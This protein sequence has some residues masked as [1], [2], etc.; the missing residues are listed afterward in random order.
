MG[1]IVKLERSI[2]PALDVPELR[3]LRDVVRETHK[4][5]GI[6]GYKVGSALTILYGLPKLVEN[7]RDITD[8]PIIY[9][10]QKWMTDIPEI[11]KEV[12][13]AVKKSGADAIIGFPQSG[14]ITQEAYI[15]AAQGAGLG[16]IVGG[17]MTHKGYKRS[18][19]GYIEDE[20][21]KDMYLLSARLG[22]ID[23]VVPGNK[24]GKVEN[25]RKSIENFV[26]GFA[27]CEV[28]QLSYWAPG[29]VAQGGKIT[30]AGLAAGRSFHAIVG[31]GI[32]EAPDIAKAA[33]ELT[34][35][36]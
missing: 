11:G 23:F 4:I 5:E 26:T 19:G 8:L 15:N 1:K 36:L 24:A 34:S 13:L 14:P 33:T 29:L 12:V 22:V 17:E 3:Q 28:D 20:K 2:I 25:Y 10:H 31:R 18:E 7:I 35:Q 30:E 16:I 9:D 21:L 27:I 6:G 32:Y